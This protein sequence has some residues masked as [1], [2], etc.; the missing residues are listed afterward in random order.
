MNTFLHE[1]VA[2]ALPANFKVRDVAPLVLAWV[3][4]RHGMIWS[5]V[6]RFGAQTLSTAPVEQPKLRRELRFAV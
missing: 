2:A 4:P 5:E 1:N 6:R 3:R